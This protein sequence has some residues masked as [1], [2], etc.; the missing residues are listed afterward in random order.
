MHAP[1]AHEQGVRAT[2]RQPLVEVAGQH[3]HAVLW[4]AQLRRQTLGLA[5]A[6][7][8]PQREVRV[9]DA[10]GQTV[11]VEV[12]DHHAALLELVGAATDVVTLDCLGGQLGQDEVAV[13][14]APARAGRMNV[15]GR[16]ELG[17]EVGHAERA[18]LELARVEFLD[19][20]DVGVDLA[21]HGQNPG[22]IA[23]TVVSDELM[24]VVGCETQRPFQNLRLPRA[25][26]KHSYQ[27]P[28][29]PLPRE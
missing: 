20:E 4:R 15:R 3:Q 11:D 16:A 25:A 29:V 2:D 23:A 18:A 7:G 17:L 8:G 19:A 12:G 13:I 10:D 27:A 22:G 6:R 24:D 9:G 26:K 28:L 1:R 21:E 5:L 14:A